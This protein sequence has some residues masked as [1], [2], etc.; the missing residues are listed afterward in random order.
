MRGVGSP[1]ITTVAPGEVQLLACEREAS[2]KQLQEALRSGREA[3]V[4]PFLHQTHLSEE[5]ETLPCE[6]KSRKSR[7]RCLRFL[8]VL[9]EPRLCP[10]D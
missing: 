10:P 1:S 2:R 8:W 4:L 6:E 9:S 3:S 5:T 7:V